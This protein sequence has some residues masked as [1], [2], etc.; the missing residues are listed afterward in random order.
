MNHLKQKYS[1]EVI[2]YFYET[3]FSQ[4]YIGPRNFLRDV[5]VK[6]ENDIQISVEGE[7]WP[8]DSLYIIKAVEQLN[9]LNL[10]IKLHIT[11]DTTQANLKVYFGNNKY[12]EKKLN[13]KEHLLGLGRFSIPDH[14]ST[15]KL[16]KVGIVNNTRIYA[17][18]N[19]SESALVRQ[20]IILEEI[21]QSLGVIGDSWEIYNSVF[22]EGP[23][24][25]TNLYE[26]DKEVIRL[27]YEPTIPAKYPRKQFERDF[28]D[29]LY[30]KNPRRKIIKYVKENKVPLK[31]LEYI[32]DNSFHDSSLYKYSR[33]VFVKVTGDFQQPDLAF[34]K[35]VVAALNTVSDQF[36]L[37]IAPNDM[38]HQV[39][40]INIQY[41]D[42]TLLTSPIAERILEPG[43]F[44]FARRVRGTIKLSYNKDDLLLQQDDKN[45]IL[46]KSLYKIMGFDHHKDEVIEID[47]DGNIIFK[48]DFKEMLSFLYNPVI[49]ADF[50]LKDMNKVIKA[51]KE[52]D[53]SSNK[54]ITQ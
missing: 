11:E 26:L 24:I 49:P 51:L 9:A 8:N 23:K 19:T 54:T 2:N 36:Q 28:K 44:I 6:W 52:I 41:N 10:P 40:A 4:D 7:L 30:H 38:W 34:C 21:T 32:R 33:R 29:V 27:L 20:S 15:I 3:V 5:L 31:Y 25:A 16:A 22:F 17:K 14:V 50:S 47:V 37:E 46:F 35:K 48:P 12:L 43:G 45:M 18:L 53:L 1:A 39:P 13:Y 42:S